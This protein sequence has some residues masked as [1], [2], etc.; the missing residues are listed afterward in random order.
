MSR[1]LVW[2]VEG[3]L[4][5]AVHTAQDPSRIE[6]SDYV[7][8]AVELSVGEDPRVYVVS[9]GGGPDGAQRAELT[10]A[11]A[12]RPSPTVLLTAS[13][14]VRASIAVFNWFNPKMNAV[15]LGEHDLACKALGLSPEESERVAAIRREL[16]DELGISEGPSAHAAP[17]L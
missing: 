14:L 15:G 5:V 4:F 7:R 6:W 1:K 11:L 17:T 12:G 2:R 8:T 10:T 9:Y 16:E 13:R 3:R